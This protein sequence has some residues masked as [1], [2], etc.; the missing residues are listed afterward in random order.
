[1]PPDGWSVK[2][3][4]VQRIWR[5]KVLQRPLPCKWTRGKPKDGSRN[6]PRAGY[7]HQVWAIDFQFDQTLDGRVLK[8]LNKIDEFSRVCLTI[9]VVPRCQAVDV[10]DTIEA[11]P[12]LYAPPTHLRLDNALSSLPMHCKSSAQTPV[13]V[14]NTSR[15]AHPA[16]THLWSRSTGGSEASS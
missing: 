16:R 3:T 9:R 14:R 10:M 6:L 15:Q 11:L 2:D 1:M 8:F 5:Q 13:W 4:R 12:K 7:Q